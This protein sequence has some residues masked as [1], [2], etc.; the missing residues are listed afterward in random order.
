MDVQMPGMDGLQTLAALREIDRGVRCVF[1]SGHLGEYTVER[2]QAVGA[3][4]V[5][6]KP[7]ANLAE[8]AR[9]LREA[10]SS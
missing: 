8:V 7:F 3:V 5:L 6:A 4:R 9:V 10:A 1:M 2:L